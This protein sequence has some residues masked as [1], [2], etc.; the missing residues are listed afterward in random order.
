MIARREADT[1]LSG[2]VETAATKGV[3]PRRATAPAKPAPWRAEVS[4]VHLH[5]PRQRRVCLASRLV[6]VM[7]LC[8]MVQR[9]IALLDP[10]R[11]L[12]PARTEEI[13]F[14][15]DDQVDGR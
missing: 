5:P 7:I 14:F 6:T 11:W 10:E 3:L 9:E 13:P 8:F 4:I 2:L 12:A 15:T 1:P